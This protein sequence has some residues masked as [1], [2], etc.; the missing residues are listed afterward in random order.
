MARVTALIPDLLFG[1]RVKE[2]LTTAG[3]EVSLV[4][5]EDD[6]RAQAPE[7][8]LLVVDLVDDSFDGAALVESMLMGREL[9][10]TRTLGFYAH[11]DADVRERAL[12]AGFDLVV[13]R[14]RMAREG[15]VLVGKLTNLAD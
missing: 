15:A 11:V 13:P 12:E 2:A 8:D 4:S 5:H 14:S 10:S 9:G 6:A 1:S 7:G 3:H